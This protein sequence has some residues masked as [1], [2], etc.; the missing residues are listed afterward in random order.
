M[1]SKEKI[2]FYNLIHDEEQSSRFSLNFLF[3]KGTYTNKPITSKITIKE[4]KK[5]PH[6]KQISLTV[7][8]FPDE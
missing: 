5:W 2:Y 7:K 1:T 3:A 4:K 6:Y 8:T